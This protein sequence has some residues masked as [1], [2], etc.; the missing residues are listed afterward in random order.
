MTSTPGRLALLAPIAF[1]VTLRVWNLPAQVLIGDERWE[2]TAALAMPLGEILTNFV[3]ENANYSAPLSALFRVLFDAGFSLGEMSLRLPSLLAGVAALIL[4]PRLASRWIGVRAAVLFA[5][6]LAL[7]PFLVFYSRMIRGYMPLLLLC[8]CAL[9][10]F[11]RSY[12]TRSRAMGI[13]YVVLAT[14]SIQLHLLAAPLVLSPFLFAGGDLVLRRVGAQREWGELIALGCATLLGLAVVLGPAADSLIWLLEQRGGM[15]RPSLSVLGAASMRLAGSQSVLPALVFFVAAARGLIL[16]SI[17]QRAFAALTATA[18]VGELVTI[19]IVAPLGVTG[20]VLLSRYVITI[21]PILLIWAAVG[22]ARPVGLPGS[23]PAR[24]SES[25]RERGQIAGIVGF[26]LAL[27]LT[28]PI[29][30]PEF[31]A[32]AFAH[33]A[34]H[35]DWRAPPT[36]APSLESIAFYAS[37]RDSEHAGP[38]IESPWHVVIFTAAPSSYEDLHGQDVI[39]TSPL[40]AWWD[41][42]R[43]ALHNTLPFDPEAFLASSARHLVIH[44]QPSQEERTYQVDVADFDHTLRVFRKFVRA[45]DA[46]SRRSAEHVTSLW[47]APDYRDPWIQVWDLERLRKNGGNR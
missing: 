43:L 42:E 3:F 33:Q 18:L 36:I 24:L 35:R 34:I 44:L 16:L 12:E 19:L 4:L 45:F 37:L 15:A 17:E 9:L 23:L 7:S 26:L 6:L 27:L 32:S 38:L 10:V 20:T 30:A 41:D 8:T 22:L 46:S 25:T 39:V 11:M 47:G 13:L 40:D 1:G 29:A 31:R 21:L 14:L 2:P 5:W 28:G